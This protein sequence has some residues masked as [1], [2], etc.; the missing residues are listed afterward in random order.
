MLP[1]GE[2]TRGNISTAVKKIMQV[3]LLQL[4]IRSLTAFRFRKWLHI[5]HHAYI[6]KKKK[7]KDELGVKRVTG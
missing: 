7:K 4:V 2:T 6:K 3:S 1:E 5:F